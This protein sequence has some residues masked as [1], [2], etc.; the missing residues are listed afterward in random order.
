MAKTAV[1]CGWCGS[2]FLIE[3]GELNRKRRN[4]ITEVFCSRSRGGY[5]DNEKN[6]SGVKRG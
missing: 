6:P 3:K 1:H 2:E 5:A 4:G